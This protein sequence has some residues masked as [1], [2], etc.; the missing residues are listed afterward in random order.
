MIGLDHD[1]AGISTDSAHGPKTTGNNRH[2]PDKQDTKPAH[3]THEQTDPS[4][5]STPGISAG[6]RYRTSSP[7]TAR[8]MIIRWISDVPSKI[9]KILEG[10]GKS[11]RYTRAGSS[12]AL[13]VGVADAPA[14]A[15]RVPSRTGHRPLRMLAAQ[16]VGKPVGRDQADTRFRRLLVGGPGLRRHPS[17]AWSRS[18]G[19]RGAYCG[20]ARPL[21]GER[22]PPLNSLGVPFLPRHPVAH[23]S[24]SRAATSTPSAP[25]GSSGLSNSLLSQGR[26]SSLGKPRL[27]LGNNESICRRL[28]SRTGCDRGRGY[29]WRRKALMTAR[30]WRSPMALQARR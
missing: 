4:C 6:Q 2:V 17:R 5:G 15:A 1:A 3:P 14:S 12:I 29:V 18:A 11:H 7:V 8:P 21:Q 27:S 13:H 30:R 28:P 26:G 16:Q 25:R 9:V 24:A 20:G 22:Q 23:R 10:I 19:V